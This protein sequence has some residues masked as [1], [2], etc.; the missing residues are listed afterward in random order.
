MSGN[1]S[2]HL[3]NCS[4]L[5]VT[6]V[7]A[8]EIVTSAELDTALAPAYTET[9]TVA[10]Q[11]ERLAGVKQRR[12][13]PA[14]ED[15]TDGAVEAGRRALHTAGISPEQVG[16]VINA[17]VT[18]PHLEPGI[19]AK[20][21]AELGLPRNCMDFDVTNACLG[22]VNGMQ[23]AGTMIDAGQIR[24]GLIVASESS[25]QMQEATIKRLNAGGATK[26]DV[27]QAFATMTL[28]SGAVAILIGP[29]DAHPEGHRLLGGITRA[30]TEH[31]RLCVG[32]MDGMRTEASKLF[33]EGIDLALDA[34]TESAEDGWDWK[35][36]DW[37]VAHQ[38]STA[39]IAT[40][41]QRLGKPLEKFPTTISEYGNIGPAAMPYTLGTF[42]DQFATGDR[43]L[44]M[45]IGSGLN[46]SF[47]EVQ[48]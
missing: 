39:H 36:M 1:A 34:Y 40:L 8:P 31:H 10:G 4:I 32:S 14:D 27:K 43:L 12:W 42:Q 2:Y 37:Y 26:S 6:T 35:D 20:V 18:R 5:A 38:T 17:S 45:G 30:G 47:V 21:H 7:E 25:R 33:R 24:Y 48:W 44:L 22:V 15:F 46:A 16:L 3:S 9:R 41:A 11:L 28:G 23:I 13:F 19:S 29:T